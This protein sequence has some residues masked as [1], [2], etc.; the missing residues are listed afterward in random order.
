MVLQS[1]GDNLSATHAGLSLDRWTYAELDTPVLRREL[2]QRSTPQFEAPLALT[3]SPN[4]ASPGFTFEPICAL[5]P[6]A[7]TFTL[8]DAH[9][10]LYEWPIQS[11]SSSFGLLRGFDRLVGSQSGVHPSVNNS[12]TMVQNG[13]QTAD[14]TWL[15]PISTPFTPALMANQVQFLLNMEG[16]T[17]VIEIAQGGPSL[18]LAPTDS[19]LHR[20]ISHSATCVPLAQPDSTQGLPHAVFRSH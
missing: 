10:M 17:G 4:S 9:T 6:T 11:A 13:T 7:P 20:R 15:M 14:L 3:W 5:E 2:I 18:T 8:G 19:S 12:I 1:Y 16:A